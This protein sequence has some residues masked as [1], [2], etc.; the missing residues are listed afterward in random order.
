MLFSAD[1]PQFEDHPQ[2]VS[3]NDKDGDPKSVQH[4]FGVF[5]HFGLPQFSAN[6]QVSGSSKWFEGRVG[7]EQRIISFLAASFSPAV[8]FSAD[9]PGLFE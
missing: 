4:E 2:V 8:L 6:E 5:R 9:H 7:E 1:R 3:G